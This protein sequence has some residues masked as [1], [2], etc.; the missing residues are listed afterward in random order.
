MKNRWRLSALASSR[1]RRLDDL[2]QGLPPPLAFACTQSEVRRH[3]RRCVGFR[4]PGIAR[5]LWRPASEKRQRG[6]ALRFGWRA[7]LRRT[8]GAIAAN[9]AKLP[10]FFR[11]RINVKH[12]IDLHL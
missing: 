6:A 10:A 4:T 2:Q 8:P 1:C 12:K 9:I 5:M 3:V 7:P 11:P